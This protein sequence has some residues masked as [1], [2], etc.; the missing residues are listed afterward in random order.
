M[1]WR[2]GPNSILVEGEGDDME[3]ETQNFNPVLQEQ[4]NNTQIGAGSSNLTGNAA[5]DISH[6]SYGGTGTAVTSQSMAPSF[7]DDHPLQR[8]SH[9]RKRLRAMSDSSSD[10]NPESA[11]Y[12]AEELHYRLWEEAQ[13]QANIERV[14]AWSKSRLLLR[15][16]GNADHGTTC[17]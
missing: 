13:R 9:D 15:D 10:T 16:E 11:Q 1:P 4:G 3:T 5:Q 17:A 2:E 14:M 7:S 12:F 6:H 8:T